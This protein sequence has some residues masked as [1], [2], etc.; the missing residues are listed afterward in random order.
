LSGVAPGVYTFDVIVNLLNSDGRA[1]YETIL[2]ILQP[3]QAPVQPVEVINKVKIITEVTFEEVEDD[4]ECSNKPGSAGLKYPQDKRTECEKRD[5]DDCEKKGMKTS[6]GFCDNIYELFWDDDCF[7]FNN[8]KECSTW[9]DDGREKFCEEFPNDKRCDKGPELPICDENTPAGQLCRDE[10]DFD[11]CD[12]GYVDSGRGCEPIDCEANPQHADCIDD[13]CQGGPP[14]IDGCPPEKESEPIKD[15]FD[16]NGQYIPENDDNDI[17]VDTI[18]VDE[19]DV[20]EDKEEDETEELE[21]EETTEEES[22]SDGTDSG[23]N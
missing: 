9:H 17:E 14:G 7:G 20:V 12:R 11:S 21:E 5:Y 2:V 19:T 22:E 16:D 3:G 1:A 8:A 10:G 15:D 18:E 4:D 13:T 6:G 23:V